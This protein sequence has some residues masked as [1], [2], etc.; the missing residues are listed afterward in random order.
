MFH[1]MLGYACFQ[2]PSE[3]NGLFAN[4]LIGRRREDFLEHEGVAA[5]VDELLVAG[6]W[7]GGWRSLVVA[8]AGEEISGAVGECEDAWDVLG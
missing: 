3:A 5:A 8:Q 4:C 6:G 7:E 1:D 2:R